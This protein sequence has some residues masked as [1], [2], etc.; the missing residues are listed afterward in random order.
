MENMKTISPIITNIEYGF[1]KLTVQ[2]KAAI[3]FAG[4]IRLSF[5]L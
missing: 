4:K 2:P 5:L 1:A 3:R